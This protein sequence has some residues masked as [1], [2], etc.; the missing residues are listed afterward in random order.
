ML[1][2]INLQLLAEQ[3]AFLE[4]NPVF[5]PRLK[6]YIRQ[7]RES[8]DVLLVVFEGIP[9]NFQ[10]S[11][12]NNISCVIKFLSGS[13]PRSIPYEIAYA[14]EQALMGWE[15]ENSIYSRESII[16]TGI[17]PTIGN[18]FSFLHLPEDFYILLKTVSNVDIG[19]RLVQICLPEIYRHKPLYCTPLYHEL[20]HYVAV[21]FEI[22]AAWLREDSALSLDLPIPQKLVDNSG[23]DIIEFHRKYREEIFADIFAAAY[24]GSSSI[25]QLASLTGFWEPASETHPSAKDRIKIVHD[26]LTETHNPIVDSLFKALEAYAEHGWTKFPKLDKKYSTIDLGGTFGNFRPY[27]IKNKAEMYGIFP[28]A[29]NFLDDMLKNKTGNWKQ[30]DQE[31]KTEQIVNNLVEKTIRNYMIENKWNENTSK[32]AHN[33]T[34]EVTGG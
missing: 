19:Y 10:V 22:V 16:T 5:N 7:L 6:T 1:R 21:R 18:G 33:G 27:R 26:F 30:F 12:I 14:L 31:Q 11:I 29:W 15:N 28:A 8:V 23:K 24:A 4:E 3:L 17:S 13:T 9:G 20:G 25:D 32:T 34:L 2:R